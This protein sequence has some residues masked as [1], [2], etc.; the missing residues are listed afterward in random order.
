MEIFVTGATGFVGRELVHHLLQQ[1]HTVRALV[2]TA[3][4]ALPERVETVL[5]DATEYHRLAGAAE[6]CEAIINLIGI[7]R[8]FPRRGITFE[9]LHT[10]TTRNLVRLA[11]DCHIRR[12]VQMS[13]NGTRDQ[14]HSAYHQSKR[15]AE[16]LVIESDLDWTI[17]RPSLI[18]GP[19]DQ[20]VNMLAQQ[21][22]MLPVVPVLGDGSYRMQPVFVK[23]VVHSFASCLERP[24]CLRQVYHCCGTRTLS[25]DELLDEIGRALDKKTPVRKFHQPLALMRPL[26][27]VLQ[28]L[29]WFP[30]T[31]E[32]LIMLLEENICSEADHWR[33]E[34]ALADDD[35]SAYIGSYLQ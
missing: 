30:V 15:A 16:L 17:F 23:E 35:F 9:K 13:A 29:P 24:E 34:F 10:E 6:G 8:E 1:G 12:F 11:H 33:T 26:I 18:Y 3:E 5:G 20:F 4:A 21:I 7:I 22:K 31:S 14:A 32:Q 25:Y 2:R 19:R 28:H 27:K